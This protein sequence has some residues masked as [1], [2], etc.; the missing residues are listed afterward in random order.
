MGCPLYIN[1]VGNSQEVKNK[2]YGKKNTNII[3]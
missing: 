3:N 2:N 1:K